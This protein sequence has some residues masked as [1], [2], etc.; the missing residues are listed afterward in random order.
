MAVT[1]VS[2]LNSLY[3][4]IYERSVFVAREL[5][6]M[7]NLV[8]NRDATGW[9]TRTT[10]IRPQVSAV[11]VTET[12][13]FSAPTTFGKSSLATFTPGEVIAQAV[14]TDRELD[15]D[16]D[17]AV[18]DAAQELGAAIATKIDAD[19]CSAFSSFSTDK[20]D[21]ANATFTFAKFA[22]GIS[23]LGYNNARQFGGLSAVLHPY[24]WHD[25]WLELGKPAAT[26][27]NL[28]DV[29]VQALRDY[30]VSTLLG[31]VAI[32][33]NSNIA[34]DANTDA[35]SAAFAR[36]ALLFDVRRPLRIEPQR[37]ASA[38]ATEWNA[39]A[40]YAYGV[41]RNTLGVK[42]TADAT[43]PA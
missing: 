15:T 17:N 21:G 16:P 36:P 6:L 19:L 39:T 26:Y 41:N 35:I 32:Y 18:Q 22:A 9:M 42:Y 31:N 3:N 23:V 24:H 38:R 1:T 10:T 4:N 11:S 29:T 13:D 28:Q 43:E 34:I 37:D 5:N 20:G 30:Y 12:Q 14:M 8:E 27:T 2:D 25:L 33:T 40:G 7:T